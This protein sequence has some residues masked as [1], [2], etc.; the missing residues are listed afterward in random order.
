MVWGSICGNS[1][2]KLVKINGTMNKNIY[3]NI[4]VHHGI[5]SG[6][7]LIGRG[8][9]NHQD[10]DPKQTSELCRDYKRGIWSPGTDGMAKSNSGF[11]SY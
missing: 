4:L 9:I 8:L 10:N 6:L 7:N 11:K 5:P 3:H 1:M 2:D